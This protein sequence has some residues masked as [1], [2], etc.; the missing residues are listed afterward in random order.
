MVNEMLTREKVIEILRK[1]LPYFGAEY[2]VKR[3]GLFGSYAKG[4]QAEDSDVDVVVEFERPIGLKFVEFAECLEKLLGRKTDVLTPA[5][6]ESIRV[7]GMV[8][9]VRENIVYI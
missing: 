9:D 8:R 2:G 7:R 6:L 4:T 5:G 1:E 3:I